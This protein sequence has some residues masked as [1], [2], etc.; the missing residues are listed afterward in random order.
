M[1]WINLNGLTCKDEKLHHRLN[2]LASELDGVK[3]LIRELMHE[4]G[5]DPHAEEERFEEM[6]E[7]IMRN[8]EEPGLRGWLNSGPGPRAPVGGPIDLHDPKI[9]NRY[10]RLRGK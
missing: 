7:G 2:E 4:H 10:G 6:W 8:I 1:A 9:D 5:H 3:E